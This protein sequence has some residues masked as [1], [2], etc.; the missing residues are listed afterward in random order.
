VT[1][2]EKTPPKANGR[3][4]KSLTADNILNIK[5][6]SA[7]FCSW[8]EIADYIGWSKSTLEKKAEAK[9]AFKL[10]VSTGKTSLKRNMFRMAGKNATMA[11]WMSKIHLGYKEQQ[12]VETD[13]DGA[14]HVTI[15]A[16]KG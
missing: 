1:I 2:K 11:I 5:K 6:L 9:E 16:F 13:G 12:Q 4:K 10:G 3:P 15:G 14:A 8:D 7:L